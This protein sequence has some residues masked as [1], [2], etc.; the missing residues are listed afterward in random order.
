MRAHT[1]FMEEQVNRILMNDQTD[2]ES[3][4]DI[5]TGKH[6]SREEFDLC[7]ELQEECNPASEGR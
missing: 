6:Y 7:Q 4:I 3:I 5:E 1:G 2:N